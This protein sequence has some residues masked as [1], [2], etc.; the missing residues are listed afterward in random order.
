MNVYD[1]TRRIMNRYNNGQIYKL[2]NT[3]DDKIYIGSTCTPLAKRFYQHKKAACK[4]STR[5]VYEALNTI[6]WDNCRIVLIEEYSCANKNEL[7]AKEQYYIDLLNPTLNKHAASGQRCVHNRRRDICKE[8]GGSQ[9]CEHNRERNKFKDCHGV[10]ICDHGR[11]RQQCKDCHGVSICEHD[12]ERAKCKECHGSA[13]CD[14]DKI[15]TYCKICSPKQ[16]LICDVTVS[17]G[18]YNRHC[19]G[20]KHISNSSSESS[21]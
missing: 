5:K 21:E 3:V 11:Q 4:Y 19:R 6:G 18:N 14:H 7:I 17:K 9:I 13:I 2:V 10:S 16:C 15:K 12:R 1:Y 8:C 20:A